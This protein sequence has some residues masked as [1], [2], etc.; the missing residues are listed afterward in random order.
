MQKFD[1][2]LTL[3]DRSMILIRSIKAESKEEAL[4]SAIRQCKEAHLNLPTYPE[5]WCRITEVIK[6]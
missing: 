6:K 2:E 4:E 3:Q 5:K 1:V